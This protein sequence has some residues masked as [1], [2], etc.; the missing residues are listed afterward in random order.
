MIHLEFLPTR[1]RQRQMA[2]R[3][4]IRR[5]ALA[6][7]VATLFTGAGAWQH[8]QERALRR[9]LALV[10]AQ[11]AA[12]Q[13][14]ERTL[15]ELQ[16][17]LQE[18]R[19]KA[20][21]CAFLRRPSPRALVLASLAKAS[22]AAV[23]LTEVDLTWESPHGDGAPPR[24]AFPGPS[25]GEALP[26]AGRDLQLLRNELDFSRTTAR[27]AG[28]AFDAA[29]IH[30]FIAALGDNPR[31]LRTELGSLESQDS[32]EHGRVTQFTARVTYGNAQRREPPPNPQRTA[33]APQK[34]KE[35][36]WR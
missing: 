1:Y 13:A 33:I 19:A 12:A 22:P 8:G 23:E 35:Q 18:T 6:G 5:I 25:N 32:E 10:E 15:K 17:T 31:C 21:L 11:H 7:A 2:R 3:G 28:V 20:A 36:P 9:E 34:P 29:A 27:I 4:M 14:N 16:T 30:Q 26:A 24:A